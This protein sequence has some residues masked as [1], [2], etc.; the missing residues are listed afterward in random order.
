MKNKWLVV[1]GNTNYMVNNIGEI[2]SKPLIKTIGNNRYLKVGCLI[3]PRFS[4]SGY[5]Y[6]NL[7]KSKREYVHRIVALAFIDNP[8]K[9]RTVNHINGIKTDNRVDNLEW[10]THGE[11]HKH[12]Y[13]NGLHP[14]RMG[15]KSYKAKLDELQVRTIRAC[16]PQVRQFQLAK[17]FNVDSGTINS[18]VAGRNWKH[19]L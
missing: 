17:Y 16:T 13:D 9:K 2:R 6:I 10:A 3:K 18:I 1:P 12:A 11:N 15:I 7:G 14:K 8:K 4:N 5:A 19:L